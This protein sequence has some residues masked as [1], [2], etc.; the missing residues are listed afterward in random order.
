MNRA[1]EE[2]KLNIGLIKDKANM[3]AIYWDYIGDDYYGLI[4]PLC[5]YCDNELEEMDDATSD[6]FKKFKDGSI[7]ECWE[8]KRKCIEVK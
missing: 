8:C 2:G 7:H 6:S 3:Q 4:Q 5:P 1:S